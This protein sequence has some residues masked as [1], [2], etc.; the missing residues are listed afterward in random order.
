MNTNMK[1][2][3]A[4]GA[5]ALAVFGVTVISSYT[6]TGTTPPE[7]VT[8]GEPDAGG[9][10]AAEPVRYTTTAIYYD[11][12]SDKPA[13]RDFPGFYEVNDQEHP[14]IYWVHNPNPVPVEVSA[15]TR[16]C[17]ACTNVRIAIFPA[18]AKQS[19]IEVALSAAIGVAGAEGAA[20]ADR[21]KRL[22]EFPADR[23]KL[24]DFDHPE[25]T[26]TIPPA[27]DDGTPTWVAVQL[28]FKV[29]AKGPKK[30]SATLGFKTPAQKVPLSTD[31]AVGFIGMPRYAVSP[32]SLDFREIAEGTP[33]KS[34]EIFYWSS[35]VAEKDLPPPG[36]SSGDPFLSYSK[37]EP[38]TESERAALAVKMT[39]TEGPMRVRSGYR[40]TVT[41][42]R[43]NP[44][45]KAGWAPELDI[46][47]LEK[48]FTVFPASGGGSDADTPRI[49][50]KATVTGLV[51]LSGTG[52]ID[53]GSFAS[54]EGTSKPFELVSRN[55][56]LELEVA[57]ELTEP[58]IL[59]A[60]LEAPK[61]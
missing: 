59:R 25:V 6:G 42:H 18:V 51:T 46:G 32:A 48:A 2:V 10:D 44:D 52:T 12:K 43:K 56:E 35:I 28:N 11:P 14:V 47:P 19:G 41:L 33:S 34:D 1:I 53:L 16:S 9:A 37:P 5:F 38:M 29:R 31:F 13:F 39:G 57:P 17:S 8:G 22:R 54:R 21:A 45:P 60:E 36:V 7:T 15:I 40:M 58:K 23:W 20:P 49:T 24:L 4:L 30:I 3:L 26:H 27:A 61:N 55:L 50:L